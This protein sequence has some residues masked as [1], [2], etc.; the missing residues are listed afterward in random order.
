M[1]YMMLKDTIF[2]SDICI[3][4]I[5]QRERI[6]MVYIQAGFAFDIYP[7]KDTAETFEN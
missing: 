5:S 4:T 1:L 7:L 2:R 3:N 6:N